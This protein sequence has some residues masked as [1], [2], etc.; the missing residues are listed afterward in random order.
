MSDRITLTG[1]VLSA[2][3]IGEYDK[4]IVLLTK[5]RGKISGFAKGARR[6]NS[7]MMA[8]AN[9]FCYGTFEC[10]EGRTSYNIYQA[11]ID[12]YFEKLSLDF[13]SAYYGMYFLEF[14]DYYAR[15]NNDEKELL[16][17]LY[18]TLRALEHGRVD[19]KLIRYIYE[20]RAMVINGEYPESFFCVSCGSGE[21]LCGYSDEKNGVICQNCL[22]HT[23]G[24][25]LLES[26]IYAMQYVTA[27]PLEKL[28]KFTL[29]SE[30]ER[31]FTS[32]QERFRRKMIDRDFKTLEILNTLR[33]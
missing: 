20:L 2:L 19:R 21:H 9:P 5:E 11:Q 14:A 28:Y 26:T 29:S 25:R 4:R 17:L 8:A 32:M 24:K 6:Q 12:Q 1:M 18:V 10:F 31:E 16:K 15:E 33:I 3:P 23:R 7:P 22:P 27:A 13:E 30:V